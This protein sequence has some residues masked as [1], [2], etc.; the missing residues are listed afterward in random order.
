MGCIYKVTDTINGKIYIG[1]TSNFQARMRHYRSDSKH[2]KERGRRR[3]GRPIDIAINEH[4][5]ENFKFEIIEDNI[6]PED[7]D[8]A[9]IGWIRYYKSANP[10]I[11]YNRDLG[12][13]GKP[14]REK[15]EAIFGVKENFAREHTEEEKLRRSKAIVIYDPVED[16]LSVKSS[17]KEYS[18]E[19]GNTRSEV[20][21]AIK[22]GSKLRGSYVFYLDDYERGETFLD[23]YDKKMGTGNTQAIMSL[24]EYW[25]A[26]ERIDQLIAKL[27]QR[28][29]LSFNH[30]RIINNFICD[31]AMSSAFI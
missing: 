18:D 19:L 20:S 10:E 28:D 23:I 22:R 7:I 26:F 3:L 27:N 31:M 24:I 14:S 9:E 11:G 30:R 8:M 5:L 29:T 4:G 6:P 16:M 2:F 13:F 12:G 17:A 1:Q 21:K 15:L 25:K